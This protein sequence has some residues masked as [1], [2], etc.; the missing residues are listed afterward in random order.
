V[1]DAVDREGYTALMRAVEKNDIDIADILLRRNANTRPQGRQGQTALMIAAGRGNTELVRMLLEKKA[2]PNARDY[3][4][5]TALTYAR[6]NNRNAVEAMLR[7]AG[8]K[9]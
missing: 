2:D 6:L 4:G 8:G 5:R 7:R 3:T 1:V 9:E